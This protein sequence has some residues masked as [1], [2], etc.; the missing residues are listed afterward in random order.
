M[1]GLEVLIQQYRVSAS[2]D[3][4]VVASDFCF[5]IFSGLYIIHDCFRRHAGDVF[6]LPA[7]QRAVAPL[8]QAVGRPRAG[9][10][11]GDGP[12][13]GQPGNGA[14]IYDGGRGYLQKQT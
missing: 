9:A 7:H 12:G 1:V 10:G 8:R 2:P 13:A 4:P 14:S 6:G 5:H 11:G 3:H